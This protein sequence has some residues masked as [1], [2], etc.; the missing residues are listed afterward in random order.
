ML[1]AHIYLINFCLCLNFHVSKLLHRKIKHLYVNEVLI[2]GKCITPV[3][4]DVII[5]QCCIIQTLPLLKS[6]IQNLELTH[7][8]TGGLYVT[9]LYAFYILT[10]NFEIITLGIICGKKNVHIDNSHPLS[11]N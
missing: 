8:K 10:S 6:E 11:F 2:K 9:N 4:H 3:I 5:S 7:T 1:F